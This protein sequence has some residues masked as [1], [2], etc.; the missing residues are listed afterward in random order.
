[1]NIAPIT[2]KDTVTFQVNSFTDPNGREISSAGAWVLTASF[3]GNGVA[4]DVTADADWLVT[5]TSANT[6]AL[7]AGWCSYQLYATKAGER[8]TIDSGRVQ[9]LADFKSATSG[10]E[11]RS[12]SKQDLEAVQAAI[13]ALISGGAVKE[14]SIAGRSLKKF[15]MA[16]LVALESRLILRVKQ[17]N[18]AQNLKDGK[19]NGRVSYVRFK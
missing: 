18:A 6:E 19:P 13:R 14:Y 11:D 16:D 3:R 7:I 5:L 12:Q 17:E 4:L 8:Y 9:V 10:F 15:E 2:R 1:M